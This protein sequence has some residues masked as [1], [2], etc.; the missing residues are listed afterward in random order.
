MPPRT[1]KSLTTST[2]FPAWYLGRHPDR[3]VLL[4]SYAA[5][6]AYDLSRAC[7]NTLREH[8]QSVFGV[9]IADDSAAVDRWSIKARRGG[10]GAAGVGGP[11]TG[12]G[13][14]LLIIDD[15]IKGAKEADS[16]TVRETAR[17]W[18]RTDARTR[19]APGGA[20]VLVQTRWH[21]DD[22]AGWLL[23]EW[24]RG[25]G[26]EWEQLVFPMVTEDGALLWPERYGAEEVAA[27][28]RGVGTRGWE[29]LYQQ[30][31]A[32]AEGAIFKAGWFQRWD[33]G[34][35]PAKFDELLFSWDCTFKDT[36]G[37]DY[38]VGGAIARTGA[39]KYLLERVR[40]RM[41]LP[42]TCR[43]VEALRDGVMARYG[44]RLPRGYC[45]AVTVEDKANGPA[46]IQV[47][48]EK[49]PGLIAVTPDGGKVVRANAVSPTVE[50]GDFFI[51]ADAPW[52]D[53]YLHEMTTFPN[54]A[55]DDQVDMTT[56]GLL[57]LGEG[58]SPPPADEPQEQQSGS[59][60]N[61]PTVDM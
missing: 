36:D 12:K 2:Y 33:G 51:P 11:F 37:T 27:I 40:D 32:P 48:R 42:R 43:E 45:P 8:G 46:V 29:A 56:Q 50:A 41:D 23:A 17:N 39:K 25:T 13:A 28:K 20:V 1:G 57:R 44:S 22:L 10:F 7:R 4:G 30:R 9:G 35:L 52:V 31:P 49:V 26:E 5:S 55:N 16:E 38:V 21:E 53:E 54:G 3:E 61:S 15:P 58:V 60:W 18:Y 59:L 34:N 47:M 6:L 19:L 24:K 14:D